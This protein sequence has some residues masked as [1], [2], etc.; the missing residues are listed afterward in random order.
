MQNH[1]FK[2]F[3]LI[4]LIGCSLSVMAQQRPGKNQLPQNMDPAEL[5]AQIG[6]VKVDDLPDAQIRMLIQR[7]EENGITEQQLFTGLQARG[8]SSVE[9]QKLRARIAK[10]RSTPSRSATS[11][12]DQL[13]SREKSRMTEDDLYDLMSE[14]FEEIKE[15]EVS[16][17]QKKVFG[18]SL[19]NSERLDF[20]PSLNV[21]TPKDYT[22]GPGDEL[23]I[24]VWGASEQTYLVDVSP[25]GFIKIPN[26]GPIYV[27]ALSMDQATERIIGN[28]TRIY[29]GLSTSGGRNANTFAQVSLG[30]VRT[31]KVSVVGEVNRPGTYDISSLASAFNA[32]Y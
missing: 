8:M 6:T 22:I 4:V 27:N 17:R 9:I 28:L 19:F 18:Y 7:M 32:L 13:R 14:D 16:E 26:L 24:D 5:E 3:L 1:L 21:A 23:I 29:S 2:F 20:E 25:D 10:I 31:I 11:P 12:T 15:K 30:Q